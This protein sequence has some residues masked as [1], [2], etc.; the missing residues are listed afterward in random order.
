[1]VTE[2]SKCIFTVKDHG[3]FLSHNEVAA[4]ETECQISTN[5]SELVFDETKV[6]GISVISSPSSF[7]AVLKDGH[8]DHTT[9]GSGAIRASW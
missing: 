3:R 2:E 8:P 4:E 7:N 9:I 1:V 6:G 5:G